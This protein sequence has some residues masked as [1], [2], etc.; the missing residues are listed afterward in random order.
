MFKGHP[1]RQSLAPWSSA[2][3]GCQGQPFRGTVEGIAAVGFADDVAEN[4]VRR[5]VQPTLSVNASPDGGEFSGLVTTVPVPPT[6][7]EGAFKKVYELAGLNPIEYRIVDE[8]VRF[9]AWEQSKRL[10]NG[11]RD[12]ITLYSYGARF[13][14]ISALDRR[15]EALVE[16]LALNLRRKRL[17]TRRTPGA[18]LGPEI[19]FT[20]LPS[21]WQY[22]KDTIRPQDVAH[23]TTG[24]EQTQWRIERG[25]EG[26]KKRIKELRRIGR[27]ISGIALGFMGDPT[28]NIADSY[29][30]QT[31]IIELNLVDQIGI[32]L[33]SMVYVCEE[34]LPLAEQQDVFA[35]LCNH[36][37]MGRRGTKVSITDDA[38]N[39]QN[40]LMRLLKD[41]IVGPKFPDAQWY[42][43]G[44]QMI[45][46]L[47]IA[48]V[49]VAAAHGHK[50]RGNEDA[51][52]LKQ[53]ANLQATRGTAPRVWLTAHRH[54]EDVTDLGAIS[55]IQAATADGGSCHFEDET[56]IFATPG[57]TSLLIGTHDERGFSEVQ[58]L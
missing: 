26:A 45:T 43:P 54:S 10:E 19:S 12:T 18:G 51:W 6:D 8:T 7:Y 42:L 15:T 56:G 20:L 28:E 1:A 36:G 49:P 23:G 2:V 4:N 5:T 41:R 34:L 17:T 22:G 47:N 27:N 33:D 58:L 44:Q 57:T 39:V 9:S 46:T 50:I 3:S 53:T 38:D 14:R 13:Q 35:V 40:L 29:E 31:F 11:D 55:R 32:A 16:Q 52:L 21:D 37:Q 30:N 25:V 24:V 48:G